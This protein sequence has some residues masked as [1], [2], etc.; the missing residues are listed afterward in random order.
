MSRSLR[1]GAADMAKRK[2]QAKGKTQGKSKGKSRDKAAAKP[3]V[4]MADLA[5]RHELYEASV[6]SVEHEVEFLASSFKALTGRKALALREDFCGTAAA[7]CAWVRGGRE[8]SAVA[9]DI[10]P[11]V[12]G[13]GRAHHARK[14]KP[15]ARER[16][17]LVEGDVRTADTRASLAGLGGASNPEG[18][19]DIAVAFNFSWWTFKTRAELVGYFRAVYAALAEDGV[20][21]L[22][23]YGG[24]DA[25]VEQEEDTEYSLFTY[26]WD[27]H[28]FDPVSARYRC[29]I[30]FRFPDG[31]EMPEAFSYDWRLWTLPELQELLLEA[32]FA[33]T[34]VYWQGE[35]EDGEPS[36]DFAAVE[37]GEND[38]AWIAYVAALKPGASRGQ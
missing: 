16:L 33:R 21:M 5:D 1:T 3:R 4:T 10:D 26:V 9:V 7:A 38:P 2:D 11:E 35:D 32:G 15:K 37:Q 18:A 19:A 31:S 8:R 12:L 36:G 14:L 34:V 13:W 29:Y 27:Q 6:Q 24:A 28:S 23:I 30:H 17:A 25:Y 20:F 22:D